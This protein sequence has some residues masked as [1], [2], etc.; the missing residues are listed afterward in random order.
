MNSQLTALRAVCHAEPGA[1]GDDRPRD[2][3]A[4][5]ADDLVRRRERQQQDR[6]AR[7]DQ[8]QQR[9]E[10]ARAGEVA[11]RVGVA[12]GPEH[13]TYPR[14]SCH[15]PVDRTFGQ[16]VE[17]AIPRRGGS[18]GPGAAVHRPCRRC[19][20]P[21]DA[22]RDLPRGRP[23][24]LVAVGGVRRLRRLRAAAARRPGARSGWRPRRARRRSSRACTTRRACAATPGSGASAREPDGQ[25]AM[26]WDPEQGDWMM[27][28]SM[29]DGTKLMLP[30]DVRDYWSVPEAAAAAAALT[31]DGA[32]VR[33]VP[34]PESLD[35]AAAVD[36]PHRRKLGDVA[37]VRGVRRLRAA[38]APRRPARGRGR[39]GP[40][41]ADRR[42]G[43]RRGLPVVRRA[44]V[45]RG[46]HAA[47][48]PAR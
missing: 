1:D 35:I 18:P 14:D 5:G 48:Q 42:A 37:A 24:G 47:G 26:W 34:G 31:T 36:L 16:P 33:V 28:G 27:D 13:S 43:G 6:E 22:R 46:P 41:Q 4:P 12:L 38:A 21:G 2:H 3:P 10:A 45:P 40:G 30:L 39:D 32:A 29:P 11:P 44:H 23:R 17:R 8:P 15:V 7:R 9:A 19:R 20:G 25:G